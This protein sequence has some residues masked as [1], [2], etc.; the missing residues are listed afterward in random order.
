FV[1]TGLDG[2]AEILCSGDEAEGDE[3]GL[4][5][6]KTGYVIQRLENVP[7]AA[8]NGRVVVTLE[9]EAELAVAIR[10]ADGSP[11]KE[12]KHLRLRMFELSDPEEWHV[13]G[14]PTDGV[15]RFEFFSGGSY[16]VKV[17]DRYRVIAEMPATLLPGEEREITITL[18]PTPDVTGRVMVD[19]APAAGGRVIFALPE[20]GSDRACEV[21][22]EGYFGV[23]LRAPGLHEIAYAGPGDEGRFSLPPRVIE[24]GEVLE[25]NIT[26]SSL[27]GIVRD[28]D[29]SPLAGRLIHLWGRRQF[30]LRTDTEGRFAIAGVL[31]GE[32]H[33]ALVFIPPGLF[34][35]GVIQVGAADEVELIV[36]PGADVTLMWPEELRGEVGSVFLLQ[37]E[38]RELLLC[39]VR[40][41]SPARVRLPLGEQ[42]I[43]A[44][45]GDWWLARQRVRVSGGGQRIP[46]RFQQAGR[47]RIVCDIERIPE[48]WNAQLRVDRIDGAGEIPDR[49]VLTVSS[50]GTKEFPALP[51][52][53]RVRA[54]LPDGRALEK[55]GTVEAKKVLEI[56]LP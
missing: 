29:G 25:L 38:G 55:S 56:R 54:I 24:P 45:A 37:A 15:Y 33:W 5:V 40:D 30:K 34:Y 19:G 31:P 52:S 8:R 12:E 21:G 20:G 22:A 6:G 36:L 46:L 44:S 50:T 18:P 17:L 16:V 27:E 28:V 4:H 41:R 10:E 42:W 53:Y 2:I 7:S 11:A 3:E 48:L 32:Y 9:R 35:H 39:Y 14:D 13:P 1:L 23:T 49:S 26:T 43:K 47:I 51:G